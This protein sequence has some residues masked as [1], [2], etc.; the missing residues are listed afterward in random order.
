ML[1]LPFGVAT[2]PAMWQN[3]MALVLQGCKKVVYYI[4]DILVTGKTKG[5][6]VEQPLV[7]HGIPTITRKLSVHDYFTAKRMEI[8]NK[9]KE[10]VL[11][12]TIPPSSDA[13]RACADDELKDVKCNVLHMFASFNICNSLL[14][15]SKQRHLLFFRAHYRARAR[16]SPLPLL[17]LLLLLDCCYASLKVSLLCFALL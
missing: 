6:S 15:S 16:Q 14:L 13:V 1:T 17:L 5:D 10:P 4:D 2:A 3:A 7:S 11:D 12:E 9:K 8:T